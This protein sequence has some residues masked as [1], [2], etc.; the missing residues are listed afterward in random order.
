MFFPYKLLALLTLKKEACIEINIKGVQ[1]LF[2]AQP[3]CLLCYISLKFDEGICIV[4]VAH[5][6]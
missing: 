5:H 3:L 6:H 2:L 1:L 4:A